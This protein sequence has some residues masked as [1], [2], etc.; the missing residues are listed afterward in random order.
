[1]FNKIKINELLLYKLL[2]HKLEFVKKANKI[3]LLYNRI[4]LISSRKLNEVKKY[5][6]EYFKK[7][8]IVSNYVSFASF[9]LFIKKS[10]KD[11]KFYI[12]YRKLN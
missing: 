11:L 4:Y 6:N 10:N 5:L 12:N 3:K 2:N 9:I 1:M 8:I 7:K